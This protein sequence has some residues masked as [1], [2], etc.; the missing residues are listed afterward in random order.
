MPADT[1]FALLYDRVLTDPGF[2]QKLAADPRAALQS[3]EIEPTD[4]VLQ[5]VNDINNAVASINQGVSNVADLSR[6]T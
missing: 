1:K 6:A 2:R 3:V 4:A 5:A